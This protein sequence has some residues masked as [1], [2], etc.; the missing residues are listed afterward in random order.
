V[1]SCTSECPSLGHS[2]P[3]WSP[4]RPTPHNH[5]HVLQS[6]HN[7]TRTRVHWNATRACGQTAISATTCHDQRN[8]ENPPCGQTAVPRRRPPDHT[9]QPQTED[10]GAGRRAVSVGDP[11][12]RADDRRRVQPASL[13]ASIPV[14]AALLA[15]GRDLVCWVITIRDA[16]KEDDAA[17]EFCV[18]SVYAM[19]IAVGRWMPSS[20]RSTNAKL[21]RRLRRAYLQ[22]RDARGGAV[23][24]VHV[25]AHALDA[26]NETADFLA[27][28]GA[29][30][31]T[32][33]S[34]DELLERARDEYAR[35]RSAA[36]ATE[37]HAPSP[38]PPSAPH[39]AH[40]AA[41]PDSQDP[42]PAAVPMLDTG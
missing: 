17:T 5:T 20:T 40:A 39:P 31:S 6:T 18:D 1:H 27:K 7:H 25:R 23:R 16:K 3:G 26:G 14:R 8:I 36:R 19:N 32:N 28:L 41:T 29:D 13:R 38:S 30:M 35:V 33:L 10:R 22:L 9:T 34:D 12:G 11:G 37:P 42:Q 24:V 4:S 2:E 15:H 21:A